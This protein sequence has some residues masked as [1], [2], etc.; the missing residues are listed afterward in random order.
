MEKILEGYFYN[1]T[2]GNLKVEGVI[3]E[4]CSYI[5]GKPEKFYDIIVGCDS[6]SEEELPTTEGNFITTNREYWKKL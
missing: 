1:P 5:S 3:D 4:L 2:K 6:S